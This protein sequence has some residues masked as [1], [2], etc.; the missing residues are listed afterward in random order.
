VIESQLDELRLGSGLWYVN[1][2]IGEP[3]LF[4]RSENPYFAVDAAWYHL[5]TSRLEFRV[6]SL[7]SFDGNCF[8][9]MPARIVATSLHQAAAARSVSN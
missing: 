1:L 9:S 6:L 2:G 5:M 8:Y 4:S 7:T 3:D